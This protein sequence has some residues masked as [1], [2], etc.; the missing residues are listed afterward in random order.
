MLRTK[1]HWLLA[2]S[3]RLKSVLGASC[4]VF[5]FHDR[6][7][8]I[9][10]MLLNT[11]QDI[12]GPGTKTRPNETSCQPDASCLSDSDCGLH[13]RLDCWAFLPLM[14]RQATLRPLSFHLPARLHRES[15]R[16]KEIYEVL[17][18]WKSCVAAQPNTTNGHI[19]AMNQNHPGK[20]KVSD[21]NI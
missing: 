10:R 12:H 2:A 15:S 20:P 17:L 7:R 14:A 13:P 3:S 18:A 11:G 6:H 19:K 21:S 1:L 4:T 5:C 9:F 8:N 16:C